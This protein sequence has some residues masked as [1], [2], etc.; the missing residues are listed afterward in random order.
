LSVDAARSGKTIQ[1]AFVKGV[2]IYLDMIA[3]QLGGDEQEARQQAIAL[4]SGL[5]GAMMLSRAVKKS[6]PK[7]SD[8]L[9]S[10]ARNIL[11]PKN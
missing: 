5:V 6:D 1:S 7:L 11:K 4:F 2:E 8:E 9:L 10:S 3:A